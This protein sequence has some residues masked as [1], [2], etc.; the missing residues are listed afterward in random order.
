ML[1]KLLFIIRLCEHSDTP[2]ESIDHC[3]SVG[4]NV[5]NNLPSSIPS[6]IT[7]ANSISSNLRSSTRLKNSHLYDSLRKRCDT[8][9]SFPIQENILSEPKGSHE[10]FAHPLSHE[11]GCSANSNKDDNCSLNT[12][13]STSN[14]VQPHCDEILPTS[15]AG[16]TFI[17]SSDSVSKLLSNTS[18]SPNFV[19]GYS[20]ICSSNADTSISFSCSSSH[21]LASTCTNSESSSTSKN[22][23]SVQLLK[24]GSKR[25][26]VDNGF[27]PEH[28]PEESK[29]V[30]TMP[31]PARTSS[32]FSSTLQ[33]ASINWAQSMQTIS[34]SSSHE[35]LMSNSSSA[36]TTIP[37]PQKT[38]FSLPN[39]LSPNSLRKKQ[40]QQ[41]VFKKY[42]KIVGNFA[43]DLIKFK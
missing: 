35:L 23:D 10:F 3:L 26:S 36:S 20:S 29:K 2:K 14:A 40:Q 28:Q 24:V 12:D 4:T 43:I 27:D 39:V 8:S 33:N 25:S 7:T 21:S 34:K 5:S 42:I 22:C 18:T 15:D 16:I 9:A 13:N 30:R 38:S 37:I 1:L 32:S 31:E 11:S 41:Q 17:E 19:L 6:Q